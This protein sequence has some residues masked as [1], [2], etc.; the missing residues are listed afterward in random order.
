VAAIAPT[1]LSYPQMHNNRMIFY[2]TI[3]LE[4]AM[5]EEYYKK[6]FKMLRLGNRGV[7]KAQEENRHL[8]YLPSNAFYVPQN[9]FH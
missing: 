5:D 9:S 6:A 3:L 2:I 1:F 4:K 8:L 7:K